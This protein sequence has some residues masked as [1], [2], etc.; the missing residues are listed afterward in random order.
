ML[1][2]EYPEIT[3][4]WDAAPLPQKER[5]ATTIAGDTLVVPA[6]SKNPDAA[7]KWIEFLFRAAEHGAVDTGYTGG[8]RFAAA[9]SQVAAQDPAVFDLNPILRGFAEQMDCGVTGSAPIELRRS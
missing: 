6:Q 8:A 5:C 1:Q 3:D 4:L 9:A 7:W 2:D